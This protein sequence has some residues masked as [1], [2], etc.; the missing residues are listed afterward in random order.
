MKP[1]PSNVPEFSVGELAGSLKRTVEET[2]ANVRV[3][4]E[5]SGYK[6]HS[7]G[8]VYFSLKDA[9]AVLD[10][11]CWKGS[12]G[13]LKIVPEDGMEVIA[14]GRLTTY[15]GRSKY[16]MVVEQ[17]ELSGQ[18]SLL[19][20]LE[21]RKNKLAAE[22]LFA[23]ERKRPIPFLPEVIG[24]VTSPT[25]AVIRDI[26]H[27]LAERFPRRVLVWP[28]L[29]Q[30]EG[31]AEQVARAIAGFNA[32]PQA[33]IPRPDVLIIARGGGSVED[34]WAFNEEG[35]V[36]AVAASNIPVISAIGHETDTTL[37]DFAADLRAPTPTAAAEKAVP[38][39]SDLMATTSDLSSRMTLA[40]RRIVEERQT[41]LSHVG[42][43]LFHP[44]RL[45]EDCTLRLDDRAERLRLSLPNLLLR[46]RGE[47]ERLG[48]RL[49]HPREVLTSKEHLLTQV[50]T[51]L[52]HALSMS[53]QVATSGVQRDR[54]RAE[55][56]G[57]RLRS[58]MERLLQES[59]R[60]LGASGNLL[61]STSHH[62]VLARGY[63]VVR[64]GEGKVARAGAA[65]PGN[66]WNIEFQDGRVNVLVK[67]SNKPLPKVKM[68]HR[69][70]KLL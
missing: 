40:A 33:D 59:H 64:D 9:D 68:D 12:A 70:G 21:E 23:A 20:L 11:V 51:R 43:A 14:T 60:R 16:Q 34:L 57:T 19:K 67:A 35:V 10:A 28:V 48:S 37:I 53:L 13:R 8:H 41:R 24:V 49:R 47:L 26:L 22:G 55:Q 54:L 6:R 30:G 7:S 17:I 45:I 29:V 66:T 2:F 63:A 25:G 15:P 62:S 58:G 18:G 38:V 61:E 50:V 4:G 3:R 27:R 52:T 46:H 56:L 32:L 1:Q 36:R 39:R 65:M 69:Q 44:R 5:I 42:R 31:A